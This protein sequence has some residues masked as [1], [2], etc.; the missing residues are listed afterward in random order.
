MGAIVKLHW[1]GT[2]TVQSGPNGISGL[3]DQDAGIVIELHYT[4]I[5]PLQLLLCAHDN[6]VSHISTANLVGGS[7]RYAATAWTRLRT[8]IALFLNDNDNAIA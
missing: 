3:A 7:C 8:E 4:S 2:L 5:R 6:S 1:G